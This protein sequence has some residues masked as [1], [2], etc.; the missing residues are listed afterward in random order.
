MYYDHFAKHQ[1]TSIGNTVVQKLFAKLSLWALQGLPTPPKVLEIGIGRGLFAAH[2]YQ[3]SNRQIQYTGIEP[4]QTLCE[5]ARSEGIH[6]IP[7]MVPPFP[8]EC[9][10]SSFDL[11]VM[12][13]VLEHFRDH[14]QALEVLQSIHSL[15]KP[16]GRFL[17]FYPDYLDYGADYYDVDYSHSLVLTQN[18]VENMVLD[19]SFQIDRQESI[20]A[21]FHRWGVFTWLI[22]RSIDFVGGLLYRVT[23]RRVFFKAKITFKLN[24]VMIC[25]KK[26]TIPLETSLENR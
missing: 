22:S 18:R 9:E 16:G 13:H 8:Q 23:H 17:L 1:N 26:K 15:L 7:C 12:S 19:T 20:R 25:S 2:L 11:V 3:R 6:A 24:R 10:P 4:N 14:V 5:K 21:C